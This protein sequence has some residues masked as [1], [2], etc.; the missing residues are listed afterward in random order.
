MNTDV[1]IDEITELMRELGMSDEDAGDYHQLVQANLAGV[2]LIPEPATE[3]VERAWHTPARAENPLGAWY[4]RTDIRGASNGR[5]AGKSVAVKDNVLLAGVPLMNGTSILEGY[6]PDTDAEIV[7]RMLD[8]GA[9][10]IGKTVC[11]AYCFSGGSHT[12]ASG[13]VR[14]PH[15][16]EHSAGGSSSGSGVVVAT[17]E[18]DMAIG[19]DQGGSIRMPSSFCGIVGMKPTWSLVPYTG[20]LGMNPGIDHTGPM[21]RTVADNALLLG[22]LAGPDGVDS[23]QSNVVVDDYPAALSLGVRG[24][25]IGVMR[26]GFST[27]SADRRVG[28]RVLQ[29]CDGL[30]AAGVDVREVSVPAHTTASIITLANVQLMITSMFDVDGCSI[31]R[32]DVVPESYVEKQHEWRNRAD[33][34]PVT[35]KTALL[36]AHVLKRRFG[37]K[38]AARARTQIPAMRAAYDTALANVDAL[39]MPTTAMTAHRLPDASASVAEHWNLALSPLENTAPF[40]ATHHPALSVPAGHLDGLPVGMMFVGK[41]FEEATLYRLGAAVEAMNLG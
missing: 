13:F 37:Y 23:R 24:L 15:N 22:V 36:F 40:N 14:N 33:E 16:P 28:E 18:A 6:V 29:V 25:R 34:L 10:I 11:E 38:Y 20:V 2:Q 32:P 27:P 26:E 3:R 9:H 7:R 41:H 4:V 19:C 21:T 35:V 1:T 31:E 17:G 8:E 30:A 39:V 12:S 5:L